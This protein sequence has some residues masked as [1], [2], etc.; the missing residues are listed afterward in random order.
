MSAQSKEGERKNNQ[1]P[2][3][4]DTNM[5]IITENTESTQHI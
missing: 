4:L 3:L 5:Q 1:Y 2:E